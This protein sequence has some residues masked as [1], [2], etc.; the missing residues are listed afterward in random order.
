MSDTLNLLD[1][2]SRIVVNE[3]HALGLKPVQ[4]EVLGYLR[5]ANRVSRTPG[6]VG[7]Y[8]G[9]TKGTVSQTL[10]ALERKGVVTRLADPF[11]GRKQN[12]SLTPAGEA[13]VSRDPL[14]TLG[15][16]LDG[17]SE[18][19]QA[20]LQTGLARLLD[21]SLKRRNGR[22]FGVCQTCRYFRSD[23]GEFVC[24]LLEQLI[25]AGEEKARCIEYAAE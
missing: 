1:R 4:W 16:A 6:G 24:G 12:L 21:Q 23:A 9:L 11:D 3:R 20:A 17:L 2:L 22:P 10:L 14:N 18:T 19:D 8:L 13:L 7:A 15:E 25:P 5:D